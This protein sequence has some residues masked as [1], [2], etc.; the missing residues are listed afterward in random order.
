MQTQ[1]SYMGGGLSR[2]T[3]LLPLHAQQLGR[4]YRITVMVTEAHVCD[5]LSQGYYVAL[6]Q[7]RVKPVTSQLT[8]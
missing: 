2:P 6:E 7:P 4:L 3:S 8:C 5:Q 1:L